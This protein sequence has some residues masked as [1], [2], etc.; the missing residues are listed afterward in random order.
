MDAPNILIHAGEGGGGGVHS[1][2]SSL[3]GDSNATNETRA[4]AYGM[5]PQ[6]LE[7]LLPVVRGCHTLARISLRFHP[8]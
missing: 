8:G 4:A 3:A 7:D 5:H 6:L 1:V 2:L